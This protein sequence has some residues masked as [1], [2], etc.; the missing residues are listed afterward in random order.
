MKIDLAKETPFTLR[1]RFH[2]FPGADKVLG[3]LKTGNTWLPI[4]Y[5]NDSTNPPEWHIYPR[6]KYNG[7]M[8]LFRTNSFFEWWS[9]AV[10]DICGSD[11]YIDE[12]ETFDWDEEQ[13]YLPAEHPDY[14]KELDR[15]KTT[16]I[17]RENREREHLF[18]VQEKSR[19]PKKYL[20]KATFKNATVTADNQ[21]AFDIAKGF[22]KS[23]VWSLTLVGEPGR[24]KTFLA[25]AIG[26]YALDRSNYYDDA[27]Y[28]VIYYQVE[29]LLDELRA[30]Y[31]Y[32][33]PHYGDDDDRQGSEPSY[34]GVM[35]D[36]LNIRLLILDDLGA[37]KRTEWASGKLDQI[38]D[39]R[40]R[41]GRKTVVTT[42]VLPEKLG[43]RISSRLKEGYR[44]VVKGPDYR[45]LQGLRLNQNSGSQ[46]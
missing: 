19:I 5:T 18:K 11:I 12:S 16:Q 17:E 35:S 40:Y 32:K 34:D 45:V 7:G 37:E 15:V 41:E 22:L 14:Q 24:G 10:N 30:G 2:A 46:S 1:D 38:I 28:P 21:A 43:A 42:N 20:G 39:T 44:V 33:G 27:G 3:K 23:D 25:M 8:Y 36:V 13:V 31:N 26:N 6:A 4:A 29:D 9:K